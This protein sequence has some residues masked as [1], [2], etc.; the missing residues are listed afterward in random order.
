MRPNPI[1]YTT[2]EGGHWRS[3]LRPNPTNT[4]HAL[5]F[6]DGS[7]FDAV[8]GWREDTIPPED[9]WPQTTLE[10]WRRELE[11]YVTPGTAERIISDAGLPGPTAP[12]STPSSAP[13]SESATPT[14]GSSSVPPA[15][16]LSEA[17]SRLLSLPPWCKWSLSVDYERSNTTSFKMTS[18][19]A[20]PCPQDRH[21]EDEELREQGWRR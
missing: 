21:I 12:T 20:R 18:A 1:A 16:I 7:E 9:Q 4:I 3:W 10:R 13:S 17:L 15:V 14:A 8:N 2:E 5:R 19:P 11:Y 6:S